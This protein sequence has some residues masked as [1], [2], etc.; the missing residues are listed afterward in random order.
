M[1]GAYERSDRVQFPAHAQPPNAPGVD[2]TEALRKRLL[3]RSRQR[4]WLEVDLLLGSWA[5]RT[6]HRLSAEQLGMYEAFMNQETVDIYNI[7]MAKEPLPVDQDNVVTRELLQ[8]VQS[9]PLG[10]ASPQVRAQLD[11]LFNQQH[12]SACVAG[13][14][15]G[16][17]DDE[18]LSAYQSHA[19]DHGVAAL[20]VALL[21]DPWPLPLPLQPCLVKHDPVLLT[22]PLRFTK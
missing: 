4:G 19:S 13:I 15:G 7:L 5:A 6:L 14:R 16:E 11:S 10:K 2:A 21:L 18:Q 3:Y 12:I 9:N 22:P 1:R 8:F 20:R 17:E